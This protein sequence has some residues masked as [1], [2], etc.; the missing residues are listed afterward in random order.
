MKSA[1]RGGRDRS[2][3]EKQKTEGRQRDRRRGRGAGV[4]RKEQKSK[5]AKTKIGKSYTRFSSDLW[6]KRQS[7]HRYFFPTRRWIF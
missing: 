5:T 2:G 3:R 1:G 7:E 4:K 6:L